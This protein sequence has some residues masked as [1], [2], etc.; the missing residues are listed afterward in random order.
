[1]AIFENLMDKDKVIF[2]ME[3]RNGYIATYPGTTA[4]VEATDVFVDDVHFFNKQAFRGAKDADKGYITITD[5][6]FKNAADTKKLTIT[7]WFI[8]SDLNDTSILFPYSGTRYDPLYTRYVFANC[9]PIHEFRVENDLTIYHSQHYTSGSYYQGSVINNHWTFMVVT[10]DGTLQSENKVRLYVDG[11]LISPGYTTD[12]S[13]P[14][15]FDMDWWDITKVGMQN[16]WEFPGSSVAGTYF[17]SEFTVY[18]DCLVYDDFFEVPTVP[19][20]NKLGLTLT[21]RTYLGKCQTGSKDPT[22]LVDDTWDDGVQHLQAYDDTEHETV[23]IKHPN[24]SV[25]NIVIIGDSWCLNQVGYWPRYLYGINDKCYSAANATSLQIYQ[26]FTRAMSERD[27]Q[28]ILCNI[29]EA[30]IYGNNNITVDET[31]SYVKLM[32][33]YCIQHR[34]IF[35]LISYTRCS[36]RL[37]QKSFDTLTH[38][39]ELGEKLRNYIWEQAMEYPFVIYLDMYVEEDLVFDFHP[40]LYQNDGIHLN[41]QGHEVYARL[42]RAQLDKIEGDWI[43]YQYPKNTYWDFVCRLLVAKYDVR[44]DLLNPCI[45]TVDNTAWNLKLTIPWPY[46]Q[47]KEDE[48]FF[49]VA[50]NGQFVPE[51]DYTRIDEDHIQLKNNPYNCGY[52]QEWKFVFLHK[53]MFYSVRKHEQS[54]VTRSGTRTYKYDSPYDKVVDLRRRV[55][56]YYDRNFLEPDSG[57]YSWNDDTCEITFA[58]NLDFMYEHLIS[59][60]TFYTGTDGHNDDTIAQLPASG[61]IEFSKK[62]IDRVYDKDLYAVFLN[63]KLVPKDKLMDFSSGI[64]KVK[65]DVKTRYNLQVMN[66]SP[67]VSFLTPFLKLPHKKQI[68]KDVVWEFFGK[69]NIPYPGAYHPRHYVYPEW[70]TPVEWK[71]VVMEEHLDWYLNLVHH[72]VHQAEKKKDLTYTLKFFRSP[73]VSEP[74]PVKVVAQIRL[75]GNTEQWYPEHPTQTVIG[76]LPSTLT[77]NTG[78]TTNIDAL[79]SKFP[80]GMATYYPDGATYPANKCLFS[81]K[82]KTIVDNDTT[83]SQAKFGHSIDGIMARLELNEQKIDNWSRLWYELYTDNYERDTEIEIL[84]WTISEGP[85]NTGYIWYKKSLRFFPFDVPNFPEED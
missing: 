73:W 82:L 59:F 20:N 47:Y 77:Q 61:Y 17:L 62:H 53:H 78:V 69:L 56:V 26:Q 41:D 31:L 39:L 49:V 71:P 64:H 40:E 4:A 84:E 38:N 65:E 76:Y 60:L 1:M 19:S 27:P 37:S 67:Q 75:K 55:R 33:E 79:P 66:M 51:Y 2:H 7:M 24:S 16:R 21:N 52:G 9:K 72:G 15:G 54:I 11:K 32:V 35:V 81:I 57:L 44:K 12:D 70:L 45:V 83:F 29:G 23:L 85:N 58:S 48:Q 30:D 8:V 5:N 25:S 74:E 36:A 68:N 63:G 43:T 34:K 50:P 28:M 13:N 46:K 22:P 6:L 18:N 80:H 3:A 14:L 10:I 42:I